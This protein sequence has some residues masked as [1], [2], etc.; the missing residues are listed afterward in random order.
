MNIRSIM[1]RTG[2][3]EVVTVIGIHRIRPGF[4]DNELLFK[5]F[6]LGQLNVSFDNRILSMH[7]NSVYF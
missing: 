7:V 3:H 5:L 2:D 4:S 1:S 6:L